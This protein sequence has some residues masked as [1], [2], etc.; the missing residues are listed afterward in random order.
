MTKVNELCHNSSY[1]VS[2]NLPSPVS[3]PTI[4]LLQYS[5]LTSRGT[6]SSSKYTT[7]FSPGITSLV[8]SNTGFR[9][10]N[11][12]TKLTFGSYLLSF[13]GIKHSQLQ[14]R[15]FLP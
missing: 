15:I 5:Y 13:I 12:A 2:K 6:E 7:I 14:T 3:N 10:I 1:L 11:F 9:S 4:S 8:N